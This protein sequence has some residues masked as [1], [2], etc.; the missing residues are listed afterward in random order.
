MKR[1]LLH[2]AEIGRICDVVEAGQEFE[3]SAAFSWVD[4][5]DDV[6]SSHTYDESTQTFKAFDALTTPGFAENAYK[7]A[8]SIAYMGVGDQLDMLY[9]EL[10]TAGSISATG[11]WANHITAVKTDIPKNNPAAVLAWNR[12]NAV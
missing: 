1:A 6:I 3:V 8:R 2:S 5:P 7:V 4:C 10:Q 9:K 12:Q 11:P